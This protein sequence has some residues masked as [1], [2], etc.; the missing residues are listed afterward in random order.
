M[1]EYSKAFEESL[2]LE[3]QRCQIIRAQFQKKLSEIPEGVLEKYSPEHMQYLAMNGTKNSYILAA[4][5][6]G[7]PIYLNQPYH[8]QGE[9]KRRSVFKMA[10]DY[11]SLL[12]NF[13]KGYANTINET[14]K[15][16]VDFEPF[17]NYFKMLSQ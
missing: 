14:A 12:F 17:Y 11:V 7:F 4:Q 2:E 5:V 16:K 3:L 9:K 6:L 8:I 10:L 15:K 1:Q 13:S